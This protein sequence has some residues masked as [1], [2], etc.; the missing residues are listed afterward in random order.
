MVKMV[1][2]AQ[3]EKSFTMILTLIVIGVLIY[4]G[5]KG[6]AFFIK[7]QN[8]SEYNNF[9]NNFNSLTEKYKEYG[10]YKKTRIILPKNDKVLCILDSK[11]NEN[12]K[13]I[14]ENFEGKNF[15]ETY[16]KTIGKNDD[17]VILYPSK[18]TFK[19]DKVYFGDRGI[20][21]Y[22]GYIC[23]T[24]PITEVEI[25]GLGDKVRIKKAE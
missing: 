5:Y 25:E 8:D 7:I 10:S 20:T 11:A 17:N 24:K 6:I 4:T 19:N 23:F 1:K 16:W 3:M 2:R 21:D 22:K 18:K 14:Q 15:I 9:I 13:T 12:K